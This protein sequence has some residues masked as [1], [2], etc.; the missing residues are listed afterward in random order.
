MI[1]KVLL[2]SRIIWMI[3]I[4]ILKNTIQIRNIKHWSFLMIW[5]LICLVIKK[6]NPVLSELFIKGRKL[7]ISLVFI[8]QSCFAVPKN[9]K[10]NSTHYFITKILCKGE[11]QQVAFNHSSDIDFKIF[12]NCYQKCTAKPYLFL[13]T[14]STL[15]LDNPLCF[16][17]NLLERIWKL[18]M[19][20]DNNIRDEKLQ[21]YIK[22][23]AVKY[24]HYHLVK[25]IIMN[26]L[27]VKKYYLL[28]KV[29]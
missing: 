8:T 12:V 20:I 21:Y 17:K 6:L 14:D 27:Q 7:N 15:V 5:L 29:K 22:R 4:K 1:L 18:I 19:T 2:S 28:I 16:R 23:E 26:T 9:I 13:V 3:F 25:L 10:L 24:Q 11:L